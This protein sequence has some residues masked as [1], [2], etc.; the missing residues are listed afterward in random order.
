MK[1]RT[2][3]P[4]LTACTVALAVALA[5]ASVAAPAVAA[6]PAAPVVVNVAG[7][8]T[9]ALDALAAQLKVGDA[10]FIRVPARAFREVADAT[11]S[12]TNHVGVVVD[13]SGAEPMIGE[14]AFPFSRFTPL[15][16]FVARSEGGRVAV[17]RLKFDLSAEQQASVLAAARERSSILYDTGFDLHSRRQFCSRYVR[18]VLLQA[19]GHALGTVETFSTLLSHRPDAHLGFWK[20]WYF[21]RIPWNRETVTPASVLRSQESRAVFDGAVAARN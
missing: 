12:W 10:V 5:F 3:H 4:R 9:I 11:G 18:E 1:H 16:R 19:T 20:L 17:T 2:R 6:T 15:S 8:S 7:A 21:G 14:S 13:V